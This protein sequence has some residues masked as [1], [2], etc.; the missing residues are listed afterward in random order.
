MERS[1]G[2]IT[3]TVHQINKKVRGMEESPVSLCIG[4]EVKQEV[5][6]VLHN[7][8]QNSAGRKKINTPTMPSIIL[9]GRRTGSFVCQRDAERP[10]SVPSEQV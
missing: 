3:N 8:L 7:L 2:Y 9:P 5:W 10:R 4:M 1:P 6:A